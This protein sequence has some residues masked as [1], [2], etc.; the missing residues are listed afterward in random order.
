[1]K[2]FFRSSYFAIIMALIYIPIAVMI[3]FSFNSG[4]S[5]IDFNGF[6]FKWYDSLVHNS[7]F[8]KSILTSLF[9]AA[10]STVASV[11]IGVLAAVGLSKVKPRTQTTWLNVANIPLINADVITA[12]SLM[13]VF[14]IAGIKFGIMTLIA[15]HISFNVPY[16]IITIMPFLKRIDKNIIDASQDLGSSP[17]QTFFKV[18]LPMLKPAIITA[19]T[20]AFSMSFDDFIIS[21][22]TGGDQTNVSTFIYTAK[23]LQPYVNAFGTILVAFI[24]VIVIIWNIVKISKQKYAEQKMQLKN[25]EYK[26]K[27]IDAINHEL[28][29]IYMSLSTNKKVRRTKNLKLIARYYFLKHK[30]KMLEV[31]NYNAK[32]SKLEWKKV[33]IT[34]EIKSEKKLMSNYNKNKERLSK[35]EY[36][37]EL[38]PNSHRVERFEKIIKKLHKKITKQER[39]ISWIEERNESDAE[40]IENLKD[41][42]DEL[43]TKMSNEEDLSTKDKNWYN[44]KISNYQTRVDELLEGRNNLKL[45]LT[46]EKLEAIKAQNENVVRETWNEIKELKNKIWKKVSLTERID[47]QILRLEKNKNDKNYKTDLAELM[48]SKEIHLEAEREKLRWRA[49]ENEAK[50]E[51]I[52]L[53]YELKRNKLFASD[54]D[55]APK[56]R[57]KNWFLKSWKPILMGTT[58]LSSFGVLT[59]AYVL[60]NI[61]DLVIGNWGS[62]IDPEMIAEFE[63]KYNVKVNYQQYD[64]NESLYNKNMTFNYDVMVPSEYMAVKMANE[65]SLLKLDWSK[66]NVN[67][68]YDSE[69]KEILNEKYNFAEGLIDTLK[70]SKLDIHEVE[71]KDITAYAT[72]YFW[73]D[74]RIAFNTQKESVK[75]LLQEKELELNSE[76]GIEDVSWQILWDA[77]AQGLDV[78]LSEDSKNIFMLASEKLYGTVS[79][80]DSYDNTKELDSKDIDDRINEVSKEIEKLV[81][82]RNVGLYGDQLIDKVSTGNFDVAVIYNGDLI[83]G[84]QNYMK[85]NNIEELPFSYATPN[86]TH[87]GPEGNFKESTNTWTDNMVISRASQHTEL[88]YNFINFIYEKSYEL[89]EYVGITSPIESSVEKFTKN[90]EKFSDLYTPIKNGQPFKLHPKYDDLMI[91]KLNTILGSKN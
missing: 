75:K 39:M 68:N 22:F 65:G 79:P 9:V 18:I 15:A 46:I 55:E 43:K 23:R 2:S 26:L 38:D 48:E 41:M 30:I 50:L 76:K 3:V 61:Y 10:V 80:V 44:K 88:A 52:R 67:Y 49:I 16:V 13:V 19:A 63:S 89:T 85:S 27:K 35:I 1:M 32:I 47:K 25:G 17:S 24:F 69:S 34:N 33:M 66:I 21:Y 20:I 78:A 45:R 28:N 57:R 82:Y 53:Q 81:K 59:T 12:V 6:S 70:E 71:E 58:V 14:I 8:L 7:P 86:K 37:L 40:K 5:L 84:S 87:E 77:A 74:V 62:Y 4:N 64:S 73:G 90:N 11:I 56:P 31:K 29:S 91:D 54:D 51:R 60:N 72:P 42:I 36:Q 83:Y